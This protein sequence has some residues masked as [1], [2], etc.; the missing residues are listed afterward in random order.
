MSEDQNYVVN[1]ISGRLVKVGSTRYKTLASLGVFNQK[2]KPTKFTVAAKKSNWEEELSEFIDR[3]SKTQ[4]VHDVVKT[5]VKKPPPT[6][7]SSSSDDESD[8]DEDED[9]DEESD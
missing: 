3:Q 4:P 8:E 9:E 2:K 6:P 5:K 1:P 7:I